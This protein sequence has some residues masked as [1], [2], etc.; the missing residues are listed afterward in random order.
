M[1]TLALQSLAGLALSWGVGR[2]GTTLDRHIG[3]LDRAAVRSAVGPLLPAVA[4]IGAGLAGITLGQDDAAA[5]AQAPLAG[6]GAVVLRE[7]SRKWIPSR[8][9]PRP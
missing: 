2:I 3:S 4:V 5:I 9:P 7:V 1:L 8:T 6:V